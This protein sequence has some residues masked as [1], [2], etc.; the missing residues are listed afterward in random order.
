MSKAPLP[1]AIEDIAAFAKSLRRSLDS[2]EQLP[3]HVEM[4][5]LLAKAGGYRNF[6]H[7]KSR[8]APTE[9]AQPAQREE[10]SKVDDK[11]LNRLAR[12]FDDDGKFIRWPNKFSQRMICLWV[13]WSKI[14]AR[15]TL[16]E[17]EISSLLDREHLFGD[18][19]LLRRELVD[20]GM[21][22]RTPDGSRYKRREIRPPAQA[23]ALLERLRAGR[24]S[25]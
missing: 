7:F 21:V 25:S 6:Q 19:A 2:R 5:N 4:L 15:T 17:R 1:L 14:P 22:E 9:S 20:R 11:L 23:L 3:S 10:P 8:A 13:M 16:T 12:Y 18:H 24:E